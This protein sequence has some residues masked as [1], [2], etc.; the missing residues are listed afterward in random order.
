M[1]RTCGPVLA[2]L[3][4]FTTGTVTC[5]ADEVLFTLAA[6]DASPVVATKASVVQRRLDRATP[7][8]QDTI[9]PSLR[10]LRRLP[11]GEAFETLPPLARQTGR[12]YQTQFLLGES[13]VLHGEP[14]PSEVWPPH[15]LR[16]MEAP[17]P[18]E[19]RLLLGLDLQLKSQANVDVSLRRTLGLSE[20]VTGQIASGYGQLRLLVKYT[21]HW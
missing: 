15:G 3:G 9:L 19:D 16:A 13:L 12:R 11:R 18:R 6:Y 1:R 5:H 10:L 2:A 14:A 17:P 4:L 7:P 8:P 21:F 20:M